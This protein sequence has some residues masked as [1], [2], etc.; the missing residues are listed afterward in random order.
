M[1]VPA[2]DAFHLPGP[3]PALRNPRA[4]LVLGVLLLVSIPVFAAARK[5]AVPEAGAAL[6]LFAS[7]PA[8]DYSEMIREIESHGFDEVT[9]VV[10]YCMNEGRH[11]RACPGTPDE[12]AIRKWA[13]EIRRRGMAV[14]LFPLL[15]LEDGTGRP[16]WR[17]GLKPERPEEFWTRYTHHLSRMAGLARGV[18]ARALIIGS[19]MVSLEGAA[20]QWRSAARLVRRRFAGE[21]IY[22][23]NWDHVEPIEFWDAMDVLGVSAY[24]PLAEQGDAPSLERL[25]GR[26][27]TIFRRL[28]H[29]AAAAGKPLEITET[30]CP[31]RA[32]GL[33]KPWAEDHAAAVDLSVQHACLESLFAALPDAAG[34]RRVTLWNWFGAGGVGDG[35]YT[36]R[37]KAVMEVIR[38]GLL[39]LK[40][41]R[42]AR[43]PLKAGKPVQ[44][45]P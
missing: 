14:T 23:A 9:L 11:I 1:N 28:E 44:P 33:W 38:R 5:S 8:Y 3:R 37:G 15:V 20:G 36:P 21:L 19:E 42:E 40:R 26:W 41:I 43:A 32:N 31:A 24:F 4:S 45:A 39:N 17:G 34:V 30:G 22:S 16:S 25:T 10:R 35:G 18:R 29:Q 7:D 2:P 6:G 13:R 12:K 27:R